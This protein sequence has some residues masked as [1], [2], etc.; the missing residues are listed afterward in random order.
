M[1]GFNLR[2]MENGKRRVH[3]KSREVEFCE[4]RP[5]FCIIVLRSCKMNYKFKEIKVS[6]LLNYLNREV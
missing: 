3:L 2:E 4:K 1:I 5:I 6:Y